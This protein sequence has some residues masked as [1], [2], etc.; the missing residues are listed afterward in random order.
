MGKQTVLHLYSEILKNKK[1]Q[2]IDMHN[3][4]E[5]QIHYAQY[6]KAD[7]KDYVLYNSI[8]ITF[9]RGQNYRYRK[10]FSDCWGLMEE[11]TK[12]TT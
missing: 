10:Q 8:L 9:W 1:E 12:L 5:S 4:D 6:R 7:S 2:T 3:M 11:L